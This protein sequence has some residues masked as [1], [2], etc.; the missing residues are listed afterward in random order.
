MSVALGLRANRGGGSRLR[1]IR[2]SNTLALTLPIGEKTK[3]I[4]MLEHTP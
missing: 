2:V 1:V 3:F 4:W